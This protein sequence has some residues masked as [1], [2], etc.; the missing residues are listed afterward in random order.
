MTR[1]NWL[2]QAAPL[3]NVVQ[4]F[5]ARRTA[6]YPEQALNDERQ[7]QERQ[8]GIPGCRDLTNG[9]PST[10]CLC[11]QE[12]RL[13]NEDNVNTEDKPPRLRVGSLTDSKH[14]FPYDYME[15]SPSFKSAPQ[16]G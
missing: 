14:H 16:Y 15:Y 13:D 5:Y 3:A 9:V 2:V 6:R 8:A 11:S 10:R 7:S 12:L 1:S 4:A